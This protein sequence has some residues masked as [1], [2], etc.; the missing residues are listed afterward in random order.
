MDEQL[1]LIDLSDDF[2]GYVKSRVR[3]KLHRDFAHSPLGIGYKSGPVEDRGSYLVKDSRD[4]S[5]SPFLHPI[6]WKKEAAKEKRQRAKIL[7][8]VVEENAK[9]RMCI[10]RQRRR[11]ESNHVRMLGVLRLTP[12]P[13]RDKLNRLPATPMRMV[14]YRMNFNRIFNGKIP[15]TP[16]RQIIVAM[17]LA[18]THNSSVHN[19]YT[20]G[21]YYTPSH[22]PFVSHYMHSRKSEELALADAM[23]LVEIDDSGE[24]YVVDYRTGRTIFRSKNGQQTI[25]SD[26]SI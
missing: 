22:L 18:D 16:E 15:L 10:N 21:V 9:K 7:A 25:G 6:V 11:E 2:H 23:Q 17:K 19:G 13:H 26:P 12:R 5:G 20:H 1:E 24:Y 14:D 3:F 4:D 8:N